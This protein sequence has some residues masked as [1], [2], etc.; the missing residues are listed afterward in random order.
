MYLVI[1]GECLL[2]YFKYNNSEYVEYCK[3]FIYINLTPMILQKAIGLRVVK[4]KDYFMG[5]LQ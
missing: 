5:R 2:M 3:L 4:I 1:G